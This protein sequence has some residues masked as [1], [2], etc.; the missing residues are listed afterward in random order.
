MF[1]APDFLD[2]KHATSKALE[3]LSARCEPGYYCLKPTE[4]TK[5]IK[6]RSKNPKY[7][8]VICPRCL[9]ELA[10]EISWR[11]K[12]R[13]HVQTRAARKKRK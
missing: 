10:W 7:P 4:H 5:G 11:P 9:V 2:L 6:L 3:E 13:P 8:V 12:T 1:E